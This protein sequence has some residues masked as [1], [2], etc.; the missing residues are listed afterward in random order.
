MNQLVDIKK[1]DSYQEITNLINKRSE[2]K[3]KRESLE[4]KIDEAH[5]AW[6][7]KK[8]QLDA[9]ISSDKSNFKETEQLE[10]E[11]EELKQ[12]IPPLQQELE[13]L[14]EEQKKIAQQF[15]SVSETYLSD[16]IPVINGI[17]EE[18]EK[19]LDQALKLSEAI[20]SNS[21]AADTTP[22]KNIPYIHTTIE[23]IE[24]ASRHL[25]QASQKWDNWSGKQNVNSKSTVQ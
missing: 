23:G 22:L 14:K 9:A 10:A 2:A 7:D 18:V 4:N 12:K 6:K 16:S 3:Q 21:Q 15:T 25:K 24:E 13:S 1:L 20:K 19:H 11:A 17:I 8:R 5:K